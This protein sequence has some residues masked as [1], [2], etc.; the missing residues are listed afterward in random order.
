VIF[1]N[2]VYVVN[3]GMVGATISSLHS[4]WVATNYPASGLAA[5]TGFTAKSDGGALGICV[6]AIGN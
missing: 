1:P 3:I 5:R 2:N 4:V 6:I